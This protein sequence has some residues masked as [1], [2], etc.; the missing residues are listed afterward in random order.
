MV[1][2]I[3]RKSIQQVSE[4]MFAH[5][6]N[7]DLIFHKQSSK[8]TIFA[9]NKAIEAIDNG[10]RFVVGFATPMILEFSLISGM[11]WFYCGP[12]YLANIA[13]MIAAYTTFTKQYSKQR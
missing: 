3:I 9:V 8:N 4:Q 11:V 12:K 2:D 13:V 1:V 10:M 5:I 7:L 6:H